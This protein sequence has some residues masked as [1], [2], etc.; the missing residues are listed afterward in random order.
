MVNKMI[1]AGSQV[2]SCFLPGSTIGLLGGGQLGRM[3]A[4]A[5]R[6]M[7]YRL[8]VWDPLENSPAGQMS[9]RQYPVSYEDLNCA[10]EFAQHADVI[11]FE[12]ENI[13]STILMELEAQRPVRPRAEVLHICQNRER[14][15]NFLSS[16][17]YPLPA[18]RIVNSAAS[19]Q[20]AVSELGIP[21]VLKSADFGYDGK[22]QFKINGGQ[23]CETAWAKF[24]AQRGVVETWVDFQKEISIVCARSVDGNLCTYPISENIHHNHILDYSIIPARLDQQTQLEIEMLARNITEALQVVGLLTIEFFLTRDGRVLV[25]ELAPRP[26]N[27]GHFTFDA[28]VTSQFEQQLR[29]ICGLPLGSTKLLS[30]AVMVNLLGDL[31]EKGPPNWYH[32]FSES[33]AKLHLYGKSQPRSGRKMGHYCVLADS[34]EVALDKALILRK[35]I[36]RRL[37]E[38]TKK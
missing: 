29:A 10:K 18:Y 24:N 38:R 22:G 16:Q 28:C 37:S 5:A 27:S 12:F 21:C 34:V 36:D 17:G 20:A 35:L 9:D 4:F 33:V 32:I 25:N 8:H 15:K 1:T 23:E 7:D 3:F 14:E 30:P 19:L 13:P 11:T 31:W 2:N 26:H 6:R